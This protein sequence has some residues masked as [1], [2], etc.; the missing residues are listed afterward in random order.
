MVN[1][2]ARRKRGRRRQIRPANAGKVLKVMQA[3]GGVEKI[4]GG[5][6]LRHN[7][8]LKI[9][10]GDFEYSTRQELLLNAVF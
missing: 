5:R 2:L 9:R 6:H 10:G 1:G 4:G 8:E 3:G 7:T